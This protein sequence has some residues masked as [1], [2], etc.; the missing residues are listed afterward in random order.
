MLMGSMGQEF[1]QDTVET[2]LV[3]VVQDISWKA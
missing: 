1:G 3:C 2:Y